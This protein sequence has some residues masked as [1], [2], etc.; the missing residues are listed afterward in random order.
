MSGSGRE[1]AVMEL[2][3][4]IRESLVQIVDGAVSAQEVVQKKKAAVNPLAGYGNQIEY[5]EFDVALTD[6]EK[7]SSEGDRGHA[8]ESWNRWE[9]G[10]GDR[11]FIPDP[12]Q[13]QDSSRVA[14]GAMRKGFSDSNMRDNSS[15]REGEA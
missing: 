2:K 6:S 10:E 4:F 13:V 15:Y 3:D 7:K 1:K 8:G 11:G 5:V 12:Y 9:S 14:L